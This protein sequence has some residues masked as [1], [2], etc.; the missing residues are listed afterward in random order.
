MK[1]KIDKTMPELTDDEIKELKKDIKEATP[2]EFRKSML[3][4]KEVILSPQVARQLKELG[5]TA[6]EMVAMMIK[7]AGTGH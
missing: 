7:A 1:I 6:D 4:T 3:G 2:E 5:M